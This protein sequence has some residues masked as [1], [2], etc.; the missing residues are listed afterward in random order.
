M[1]LDDKSYT[2]AGVLPPGLEFPLE[3]APSVGTGS[4]PKA[5][6]Q[7]FW[8]PLRLQGQ[9]RESRGVRMFLGIGRLKPGAAESSARAELA[10]LSR[11][12]AADHPESN[13]RWSF[14]LLSFRD[15]VLGRTRQVMP[16]LAV[17]VAAVLL[18]DYS[19]A[20]NTSSSG[21]LANFVA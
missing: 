14:D 5:G 2:V 15:P 7:S 16:L 8:F 17:A 6:V 12:L 13:R 11:R 4:G 1:E 21:R 20:P 10:A 9:D 18:M 3:R 19:I